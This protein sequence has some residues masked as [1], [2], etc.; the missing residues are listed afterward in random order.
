MKRQL[1][2]PGVNPKKGGRIVARNVHRSVLVMLANTFGMVANGADELE[3]ELAE[4]ND[5]ATGQPPGTTISQLTQGKGSGT[6]GQNSTAALPAVA[7]I[8]LKK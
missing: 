3:A 1:S 5:I 6:A 8:P 4:A 2:G 7:Q